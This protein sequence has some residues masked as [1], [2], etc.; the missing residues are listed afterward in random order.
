MAPRLATANRK[1]VGIRSSL[2]KPILSHAFFGITVTTA[3]LSR[4]TVF[5]MFFQSVLADVQ[6][7]LIVS[8]LYHILIHHGFMTNSS[9]LEFFLTQIYLFYLVAICCDAGL[10]IL[11]Q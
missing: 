9:D 10:G 3:P 4:I 7:H 6:S 1:F 2:V 8:N 5:P 11:K